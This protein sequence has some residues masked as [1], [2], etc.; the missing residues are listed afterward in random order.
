MPTVSKGAG[1]MPCKRR[2]TILTSTS[3]EATALSTT[4]PALK[5]QRFR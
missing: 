1:A 5:N 4:S 2:G 3:T